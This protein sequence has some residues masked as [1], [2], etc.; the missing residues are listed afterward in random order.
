MLN[1]AVKRGIPLWKKN[2]S[3]PTY[4]VR[5]AHSE[6]RFKLSKGTKN[7]LTAVILLSFV[8]FVYYT[9]IAKMSQKVRYVTL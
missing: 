3:F 5:N 8:G 1:F 7:G 2:K 4:H 6:S 9:A